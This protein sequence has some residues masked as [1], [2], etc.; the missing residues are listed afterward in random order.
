[1]KDKNIITSSQKRVYEHINKFIKKNEYSP[2]VRELCK[3]LRLSSTATVH[4]YLKIL[5]EK[6]YITYCKNKSRT[7][8]VI[9]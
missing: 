4:N 9:K 8:K 1:M 3:S 7:I 6:G 2:T 5:K